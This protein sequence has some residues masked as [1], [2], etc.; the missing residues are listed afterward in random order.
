MR[1]LGLTF[2]VRIRHLCDGRDIEHAGKAEDEHRDGQIYPLDILER[3]HRVSSI[4]EE[5]IRAEDRPH[6][7]ADGIKSLCKIDTELCIARWTADG[8]VW[9]CGSLERAQSATDDK[10]G[11]AEAT[12]RSIYCGGPHQQCTD[13]VEAKAEHEDGLVAEMA[14]DPIGITERCNWV[15]SEIGSLKT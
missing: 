2:H 15:G 7:S 4:L 10:C 11:A 1:P 14:E 6:H 3:L 12:E 5:R 8:D 9:I 13:A